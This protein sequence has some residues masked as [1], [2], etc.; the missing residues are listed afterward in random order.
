MKPFPVRQDLVPLLW[1]FGF[2]HFG[3]SSIILSK[4]NMASTS[5]INHRP[6][7]LSS[8]ITVPF[9]VEG[10]MLGKFSGKTVL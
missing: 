10:A 8:I 6:L 7:D 9:L 4:R 5:A 3:S 1:N 2:D